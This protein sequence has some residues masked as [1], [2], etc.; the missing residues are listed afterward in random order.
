MISARAFIS[1][2]LECNCF[3]GLAPE[4]EKCEIEAPT[5]VTKNNNKVVQFETEKE[6]NKETQF[7]QN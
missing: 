2:T 7:K 3:I 1:T 4:L 6:L 5:K